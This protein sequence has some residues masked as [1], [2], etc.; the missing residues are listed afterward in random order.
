[1]V[2]KL[3]INR[4]TRFGV[5]KILQFDVHNEDENMVNKQNSIVTKKLEY[6]REFMSAF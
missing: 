5:K 1:M 4:I 3:I 6:Y 2:S